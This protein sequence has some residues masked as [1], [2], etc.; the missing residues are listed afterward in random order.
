MEHLEPLL[1][2]PQSNGCVVRMVFPAAASKD[3]NHAVLS[4]I[5]E[6]YEERVGNLFVGLTG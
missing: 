4:I 5:R 6:S 1:Q 2:S 3:A